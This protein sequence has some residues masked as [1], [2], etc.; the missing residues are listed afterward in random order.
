[1]YTANIIQRKLLYCLPE[2]LLYNFGINIVMHII[3][4]R[5]D[6]I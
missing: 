5:I 1:M 4:T 3:K 6:T 2:T